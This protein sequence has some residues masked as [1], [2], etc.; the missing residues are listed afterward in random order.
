MNPKLLAISICA[1]ALITT[2]CNQNPQ[3]N[4]DM[5]RPQSDSD[6]VET[7]D[8]D[9][10]QAIS[11]SVNSASEASLSS[12]NAVES[13]PD[14]LIKMM[15]DR[16][17]LP[18]EM[19]YRSQ[20]LASLDSSVRLHAIGTLRKAARAEYEG[21]SSGDGYCLESQIS[22]LA[23]QI[24]IDSQSGTQHIGADDYNGYGIFQPH[25]FSADLSYVVGEFIVQYEGGDGD[26]YISVVDISR[27]E[28]VKD[29][30]FCQTEYE[31]ASN[32]KFLGFS[33]PSEIVVDCIVN[34]GPEFVEAVDL[35]TG[36][37][38]QLSE[39]PTDLIRYGTL[40]NS[41]EV[42]QIQE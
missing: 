41:F 1:I 33:A 3:T 16:C 10:D 13:S 23:P 36:Q 42:T 35:R 12:A 28:F 34:A 17:D 25:S 30:R 15:N 20:T 40:E 39:V 26:A 32:Q 21:N 18:V 5:A 7:S 6:S 2:A 4:A 24:L 11:S 31:A 9:E 22:T 27:G 37:S 38:R 14:E 8:S 19:G 29:L